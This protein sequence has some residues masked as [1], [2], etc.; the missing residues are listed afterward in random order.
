MVTEPA[1]SSAVLSLPA[2]SEP[3]FL[4]RVAVGQGPQTD[5]NWTDIFVPGSGDDAHETCELAV[6]AVLSFWRSSED[7]V[8]LLRACASE[9]LPNR[10]Q[11][12][13]PYTLLIR[14]DESAGPFSSMAS[15]EQAQAGL[16]KLPIKIAEYTRHRSAQDCQALIDRIVQQSEDAAREAT[17]STEEWLEHELAENERSRDVSCEQAA[18]ARARCDLQ[19]KG[20]SAAKAC[21][22]DPSAL[23]C[24]QAKR[25]AGK[26]SSCEFEL[27]TS[28]RFCDNA[29]R[30]VEALRTRLPVEPQAPEPVHAHCI[31]G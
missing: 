31:P 15:L 4:A 7:G 26:L 21:E 3:G 2:P 9:P 1:K 6:E 29:N 10:I 22:A 13:A 25:R 28:T 18:E 23:A 16:P 14:E 19:R 12:G 24:K 30:L 17:S 8:S 11:R 5:D 20:P 27:A